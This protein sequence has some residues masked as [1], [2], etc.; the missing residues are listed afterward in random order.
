MKV[1]FKKTRVVK[2]PF[3]ANANDAGI[4]FFLPELN[5]EMIED[6][7]TKNPGESVVFAYKGDNATQYLVGI[8]PGS[9]VLIPTGIHTALYPK[10][11]ALI[12]FN[13]SG[14]ASKRGLIVTA[15]V[16]DSDYTGE[17]HV[18]LLNTSE[19]YVYFH[20]GDKIGQFVHVPI[21]LTDLME[22]SAQ[23]YDELTSSSDRG[24]GGFGSTDKT[25]K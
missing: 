23:S 9:R 7:K 10:P 5:Q 6:L 18:G 13:K 21:Y 25:N 12:A 2:T 19:E 15:Q 3:R 4:D 8:R 11:S 1:M 14:L 22:I 20:P 24:A 16:V 17:I